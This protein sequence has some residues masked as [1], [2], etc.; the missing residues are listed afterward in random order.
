MLNVNEQDVY[1]QLF[2]KAK[3][4]INELREFPQLESYSDEE[5]EVISNEIFKLA[6]WTQ[7]KINK[8]D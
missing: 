2:Y 3:L 8:N 6:M 4:T 7:K 1:E 5:L